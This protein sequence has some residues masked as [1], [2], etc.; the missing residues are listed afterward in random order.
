MAFSIDGGS[1]SSPWASSAARS[2]LIASRSRSI[3]AS[4]GPDGDRA[5]VALGG[6]ARAQVALQV[7]HL[8]LAADRSVP[9]HDHVGELDDD[10]EHVGPRRRVAL[11][12]ERRHAEEAEVAGEAHVGVGDEH[13][14]VAGG[15]TRRGQH[16]DARRE[17]RGAVDEVGDR[18][19]AELGE[20][21]ELLV[22]RGHELLVPVDRHRPGRARRWSPATRSTAA[23]GNALVPPTWSMCAWV[24]M[25][26]R[27]GTSSAATA[28]ANGSHCERTISVSI[29]VMPSSSTT[30]PA[31]ATPVSPPG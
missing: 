19:R 16:L 31:L 25:V 26:R 7:A 30:T 29:T 20:V 9:G 4:Q 10:V 1:P 22:E 15:V 14:Q 8:G 13:E 12:R 11:E 18:A 21:V 27:T 28:A 17:L 24:R 3:Q 5:D 2:T 6:D 23:F